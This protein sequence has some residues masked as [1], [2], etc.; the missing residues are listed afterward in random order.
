[1]KNKKDATKPY[2][3]VRGCIKYAPG[4]KGGNKFWVDVSE[5]VEVADIMPE[6]EAATFEKDGD[7]G[8]DDFTVAGGA[9]YTCIDDNFCKQ[10]PTSKYGSKGWEKTAYSTAGIKDFKASDKPKPK[11]QEGAWNAKQMYSKSAISRPDKTKEEFFKCLDEKLCRKN[12]PNKTKKDGSVTGW[13][14]EEVAEEITKMKAGKVRPVKDVKLQEVIAEKFDAAA[15][16][17]YKE[18]T[19]V[20]AG[21]TDD[22]NAY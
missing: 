16:T 2:K 6:I 7:Y 9:I 19:I 22:A 5:E 8:K 10:E 14:L 1:M 18:N 12:A 11:I 17:D 3:V 13:K 15:K 21:K 4:S 20:G